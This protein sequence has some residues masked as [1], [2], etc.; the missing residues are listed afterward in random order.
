VKVI[1][2]LATLFLAACG[3]GTQRAASSPT[4]GQGTTTGLVLRSTPIAITRG[5]VCSLPPDRPAHVS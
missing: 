1:V 3:A 4:P 5:G 2:T